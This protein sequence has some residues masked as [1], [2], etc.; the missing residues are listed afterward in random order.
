MPDPT[1]PP[2]AHLRDRLLQQCSTAAYVAAVHTT[3]A[4][5]ASRADRVH[6]RSQN[7][8]NGRLDVLPSR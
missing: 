8:S 2:V 1:Q 5:G 3:V 7:V 6:L 4:A